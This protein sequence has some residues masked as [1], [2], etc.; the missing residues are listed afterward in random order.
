MRLLFI[1]STPPIPSW[2]GAMA[3][4]RHFCEREDFKVQVVTD[5]PQILQYSVPYDY[6]LI[7]HSKIWTRLA[8]TRF[9]KVAH[10]W[11]HLFEGNFVPNE[12]VDQAK[13]FQPDVILTVAG[14]WSW[15]AKMAGQL[16]KQL[17]LPLAGSF[18]DW[19]YYNLIRH[20][21]ADPLIEQEFRSFYQQCDLALCTCE[22]MQEALGAHRNSVVLYPTGAPLAQDSVAGPLTHNAQK[23]FTVA[24]AGNL[25]EWYGQMLEALVKAAYNSPIKF[26]I[27]GSNA[28]W[29]QEFN[30]QVLEAGIYGGQVSFEHL[31]DEMREV[32]ALLLLMGFEESCAQIERTSFKTKF[33]DYLSFQKPILLWGP[34]YCS[35]VRIAQ[36]F[37]SAEACISPDPQEFLSVIL[38]V[39]ND[40]QRQ[41]QLV[42]QA[43]QMYCDRFHPDKVHQLLVSKIKEL[44]K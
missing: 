6:L 37:G 21:L 7:H 8:R 13:S 26:K 24:F 30:Y 33:L 9:Y 44:I 10:S 29:S 1:T 12:V 14:S 39:A 11:S 31:R 3:F 36:E 18:N 40:P 16:A 22:G 5:N 38:K 42:K 4:Y 25:G 34:E 32:D 2:G 20:P 27:F 17:N 41:Q 28:S 43:Y 23:P 35:A 19:W 15:T